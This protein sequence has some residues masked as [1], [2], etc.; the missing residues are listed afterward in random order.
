M[1]MVAGGTGDVGTAGEPVEGT[2]GVSGVVGVGAALATD[3]GVEGVPVAGPGVAAAVG[4][5]VTAGLLLESFCALSEQ[6]ATA[7]SALWART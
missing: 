6:A 4:P 3:A 1:G 5:E 7:K 2:V